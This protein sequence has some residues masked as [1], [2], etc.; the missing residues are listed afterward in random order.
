MA[1]PFAGSRFYA[2]MGNVFMR[3]MW[4]MLRPPVGFAILTTRGRKS[5]Q[6]RRQCVRAIRQDNRVVI[7]A[8]MGERAQW[9]RNARAGPEVKLK[10]HDGT[11]VGT[12]HEVTERAEREW[13]ERLYVETIVRN[14][15]FDYAAYEWGL[16]S[17]RNIVKGHRRW[18]NEGIPIVVDTGSRPGK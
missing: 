4:S 6:P 7:V 3:P 1:N 16:P 11:Y 17:R 13:A 2:R 14:D 9:L 15:Y 10:L 5:G 12:A 8:M 18:F